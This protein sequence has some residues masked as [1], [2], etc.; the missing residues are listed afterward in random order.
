MKLPVIYNEAR[1][2]SN[3]PKFIDNW[4]RSRDKYESNRGLHESYYIYKAPNFQNWLV[5]KDEEANELWNEWL[6]DN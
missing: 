1:F 3:Q 2:S 4:L 5:E 6:N